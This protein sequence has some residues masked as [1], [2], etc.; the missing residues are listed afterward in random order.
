MKEIIDE[1]EKHISFIQLEVQKSKMGL[2]PSWQI[3]D[4]HN[5]QI[6]EIINEFYNN[7]SKEPEYPDRCGGILH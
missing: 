3:V 6:K 2:D 5:K 1:I 4:H 7:D